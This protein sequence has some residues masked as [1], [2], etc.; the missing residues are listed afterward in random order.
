MPAPIAPHGAAPAA[1]AAPA[2]TGAPHG[3]AP[4]AFAAPAATGAPH[5]AVPAAFAAPAATGA[6]HGAAPAAFA[7]PAATGAPHEAAPKPPKPTK[8]PKPAPRAGRKPTLPE[9]IFGVFI[10]VAA[11]IV[12]VTATT[13]WLSD[14]AKIRHKATVKIVKTVAPLQ[15]GWQLD[16][17]KEIKDPRRLQVWD[18]RAAQL[19][20][21]S[22]D[23]ASGFTGQVLSEN[24]ILTLVKGT[25]GTKE[26]Q[27]LALIDTAT[28][29]AVWEKTYGDLPLDYC[30]PEMWQSQVVCESKQAKK[31]VKIDPTGNIVVG[32]LPGGIWDL[33]TGE[34]VIATV[35]DRFLVV[36]IGISQGAA[37]GVEVQFINPDFTYHT[38]YQVLSPNASAAKPLHVQ[39]RG[40]ITLVGSLTA[41]AD[42]SNRQYTWGFSQMLNMKTG[43]LDLAN[44]GEAPQASLLEAGFFASSDP[45]GAVADATTGNATATGTWRLYQ[46]DGSLSAEGRAPVAALQAMHSQLRSGLTLDLATATTALQSGKVPVIMPDKTYL[47]APT[48]ETCGA[49]S[50]CAATT[51]TT[52][53]GVEIKLKTPGKP[54]M[55]HA[56]TVVFTVAN[57]LEA[58]GLA[59]GKQLW[60][61]L[62][63]PI[64]DA[65]LTG[66]PL[67]FS[68]GIARLAQIGDAGA[69]RGSLTF[70]R[71]P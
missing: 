64:K 33:A 25:D 18:A 67:A 21:A 22:Q 4:A 58:F 70:W 37:A 60:E 56:A 53:D 14:T 28:G 20:V 35:F 2:A 12:L 41:N 11:V 69:A 29:R 45:D 49:W 36:P 31:I 1:F 50:T 17:P 19:S 10:L 38:R 52:G 32:D 6:P 5:G 44:L 15:D 57:G 66:D 13:Q 8:P 63:P 51:W 62:T 34:H 71:L 24:Q 68:G 9:R 46:P 65:V 7:A 30:L 39:S 23:A 16:F 3:A 42:G 47:L 43:K 26:T 48:G 40:S 61:G 27:A 54:L 59:D 55:N